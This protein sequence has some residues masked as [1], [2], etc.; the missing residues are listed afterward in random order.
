[1][2]MPET[3]SQLLLHRSPANGPALFALTAEK[4]AVSLHQLSYQQE[5]VDGRY[6]VAHQVSHHLA[7]RVG[8]RR[9]YQSVPQFAYLR[10]ILADV[11]QQLLLT[12]LQVLDGVI[13]RLWHNTYK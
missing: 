6:A 9:S 10:A 5:S 12:Q 4:V 11:S 2:P 8:G 13:S 1:M 7:F 3:S